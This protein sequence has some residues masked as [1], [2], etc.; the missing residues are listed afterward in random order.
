MNADFDDSKLDFESN[1]FGD[2][3]R[4]VDHDVLG[5]FFDKLKYELFFLDVI[6]TFKVFQSDDFGDE[7]RL[8]FPDSLQKLIVFL[9]LNKITFK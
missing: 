5:E 2:G 4:E 3:V 7:K 6:S 8:F 9:F 1:L